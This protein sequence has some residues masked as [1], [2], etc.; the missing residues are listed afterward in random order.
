MSTIGERIAMVIEDANIKA[1]TGRGLTDKAHQSGDLAH[2]PR[3]YH[4]PAGL[5]NYTKGGY[6]YGQNQKAGR[7][8][9]LPAD[10]SG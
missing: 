2:T 9:I 3:L 8:K 10:L 1:A 5:V 6:F 4:P 7:R